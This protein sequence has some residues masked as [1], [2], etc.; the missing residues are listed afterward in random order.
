M[1]K[2]DKLAHVSSFLRLKNCLHAMKRKLLLTVLLLTI[3]N[4]TFSQYVYSFDG[5]ELRAHVEKPEEISLQKAVDIAL[6]DN[7][8]LKSEF[9]KLPMEE[10]NL[11]IAKYRPNPY[12][13]SFNE[14]V[15]GGSVRPIGFGSEIEIGKKRHWRM[16]IANEKIMKKSLEIEKR[17]W[18]IHT[19]VHIA[20]AKCSIYQSLFDLISKQLELTKSLTKLSKLTKVDQLKSEMKLAT[21]ENELDEKKNSLQKAKIE[22]NYLL[23]REPNSNLIVDNSK[24]LKPTFEL[25]DHPE[26]KTIAGNAYKKRL[27]VEILGKGHDVA[28][29]SVQHLKWDRVPNITLQTAPLGTDSRLGAFFGSYIPIPIFNRKQGEISKAESEVKYLEKA[30]EE[31]RYKISIEIERAVSEYEIKKRQLQRIQN[32][33]LEKTNKI[34]SLVKNNKSATKRDLINTEIQYN[35]AQQTYLESLLSY[36]IALANL[37]KAVGV[38]LYNLAL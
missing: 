9:A 24:K 31:T 12:I 26:F 15:E 1:K 11:I 10:A 3:L 4:L 34:L 25:L 13:T 37:E 20:Y 19:N 21:K 28:L 5:R 27:E 30:I 2:Y 38:P 23:G 17:M 14:F 16:Q 22:L 7:Y 8:E 6:S 36:H 33:V 29:A 35:Q 32:T 18:D